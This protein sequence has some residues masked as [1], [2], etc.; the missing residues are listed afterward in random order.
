MNCKHV[1]KKKTVD[2]QKI[3]RRERKRGMRVKEL[4]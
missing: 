1:K 2:K 3:E 4:D